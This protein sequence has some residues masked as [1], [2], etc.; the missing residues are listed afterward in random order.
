LT[1][2]PAPDSP[3]EAICIYIFNQRQLEK[4]LH[5]KLLT[6]AA[7][8]NEKAVQETLPK[9]IEALLPSVDEVKKKTSDEIQTT[10]EKFAKIGPLVATPILPPKKE[11]KR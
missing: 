3:L 9:Y 8:S 11:F 1:E 2:T 7:F 10:L 5:V 4:L 6:Y